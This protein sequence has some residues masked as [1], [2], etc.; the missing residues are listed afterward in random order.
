M[1]KKNLC[2]E[3]QSNNEQNSFYKIAKKNELR[4]TFRS[5]TLVTLKSTKK[6]RR[7]QLK[8]QL[9]NV[10]PL[11]GL[12]N[13]MRTNEKCMLKYTQTHTQRTTSIHIL[14]K[15]KPL[16]HVHFDKNREKKRVNIHSFPLAIFSFY[17]FLALLLC[18]LPRLLLSLSLFLLMLS[19]FVHCTQ[20]INSLSEWICSQCDNIL[21]VLCSSARKI[22]TRAQNKYH[23]L[24]S[25]M[26]YMLMHRF[27]LLN[28]FTWFLPIVL[29]SLSPGPLLFRFCHA[30]SGN[31]VYTMNKERNNHSLTSFE[32][33]T[34]IKGA[35]H[36]TMIEMVW[37]SFFAYSCWFACVFRWCDRAK[38]Y[39][40]QRLN[41]HSANAKRISIW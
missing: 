39:K 11:I 12:V 40:W 28:M 31:H 29:F 4:Q 32:I 35:R 14:W 22:L 34:T 10:K 24:I 26:F 27:N 30:K 7:N 8:A 3:N 33:P 21:I 20:I 23:G 36:F 13:E 15:Q 18:R 37:D 19:A 6:W 2:K 25:S 41:V 16:R 1:E 9:Y 5:C 38:D 17:F